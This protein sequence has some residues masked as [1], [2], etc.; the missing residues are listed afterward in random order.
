MPSRHGDRCPSIGLGATRLRL[1]GGADSQQLPYS[2]AY[3]L[4]CHQQWPAASRASLC[5]LLAHTIDCEW[6]TPYL[7]TQIPCNQTLV[8]ATGGGWGK[9]RSF[10][11]GSARSTFSKYIHLE[12][13]DMSHFTLTPSFLPILPITGV[14]GAVFPRW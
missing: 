7:E 11:K 12:V 6:T 14:G 8:V 3:V 4:L 9:T 5:A 10:L 13:I 2:R 1:A